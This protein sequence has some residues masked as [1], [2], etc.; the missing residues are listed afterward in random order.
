MPKR[1][2]SRV[3]KRDGRIARF[4]K[5]KITSAIF[6]AA[7]S[8]GGKDIERAKILS[9]KVIEYLKKKVRKTTITIEHIHDTV[10]KVLI[11]EGHAKTA[12]HYILYREKMKI[13]R[14][15]QEAVLGIKVK[16]DL[17]INALR[18][19]K[20]KFLRR[21]EK[22]NILETPDEMF[23]RV[24]K[25]IAKAD[26]VYDKKAD[27]KNTEKE[28]YELM[29]SLDFLPNSPTLMNAGTKMQ[30]LVSSFVLPMP[31]SIDG[32]FESVKNTALIHKTG[33]G[34]GFSFSSL[35]PENDIVVST[36]GL[37]SGPLSF[38]M[39]FDRTTETI[40]QGGRKRGA[41]I[42]IINYD[43]PDILKFI[44]AKD[45][46]DSYSNFNFSV[47]INKKF[48]DAYKKNKNYFLINP[49]NKKEVKEVN[50]RQVFDLLVRNAWKSGDPGL[51]FLDTINK[52]NPIP[53]FDIKATDPCGSQPLLPYESCP[54]G[55]IN[56]T[57]IVKNGKI[58]Y[59]KLRNIVR[60]S[61]HFL[62][63]VIDMNKYPVKETEKISKSN[64]K[65]G[66]GVM[67]FA[68]ML[69]ML[70]I[71]Y[72][73]ERCVKLVSKLM[74]FIDR[75][76]KRMSMELAE[77]RGVFPNF[78]KS[79]YYNKKIKIRNATVTTITPTGTI[80]IIA[81]VSSGIE[82]NFA[83]C[84]VR[85][86]MGTYEFFFV[87]RFFE[88][89]A[90]NK[91][92]YSELL[93]EKIKNKASVSDVKDIPSKYKNIF[94]LAHDIRPEW[95]LRVQ[96]AFQKH[97]DNGVSKTINFSSDVAFDDIKN[98]FLLA[99]ELGCKGITVYREGSKEEEI[100]DLID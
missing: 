30:Q 26:M 19:L 92:F 22:G 27:V 70:G 66:L 67:G 80:S 74:G 60:K 15:Y 87:N 36:S 34:T 82:P 37:S 49:R 29:L 25:N 97:V 21:G 83:L 93:S 8:V 95:H 31:D 69:Y 58:D 17:S 5:N 50:A 28:F 48:M 86:I 13:L 38:M 12:K 59:E 47:G 2:F 84:F 68:D 55:A 98:T 39:M 3:V 11:E 44:T 96:A 23:M 51:V 1:F 72:N 71:P 63:N 16:T 61:V 53:G 18:L 41:N 65:I 56:L 33:A 42:A 73:S 77:K 14:E 9:D 24:A 94:V 90:R 57:N 75:E 99:Y 46:E 64:R 62:D 89:I 43:H 91:G 6:R 35:R 20:E 100:I 54:S 4:N 32:I 52:A 45:R 79:I 85:K 40:K 10:E 88:K 7:Q 81:D 76:A 78:N